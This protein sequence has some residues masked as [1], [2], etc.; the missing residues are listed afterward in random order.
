M[1]WDPR[2]RF[3]AWALLAPSRQAIPC[4]KCESLVAAPH[5]EVQLWADGEQKPEKVELVVLRLLGARGRAEL[6][7]RDPADRLSELT[8]VTWTVNPP[9]FGASRGA[10]RIS[11]YLDAALA[12][13]DF[14]ADRYPAA[15]IWAYGKSIGA[16]AAMYVAAH[17]P[18]SALIVKNIIDVPAVT[19]HRL[20]R[21]LPDAVA[22]R[23][24]ANVP[25]HLHARVHAAAASAP[26]LFV[27][28][29]HDELAIPE[30]QLAVHQAYCGIADVLRVAGGHDERT[31]RTYDEPRYRMAVRALL[32][33][34]RRP[35]APAAAAR[36]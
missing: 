4:A 10:L 21:W 12:A 36:P 22:A 29:D 23:I 15:P 31:L 18:L 16:T 34:T 17:R 19:R 1:K 5:G 8:A 24:A 25:T 6:A 2:D 28:S 7:T 20:R 3:W 11:D 27:V 33:R 9:R 35:C 32:E 26:A 30:L 14:L 13:F